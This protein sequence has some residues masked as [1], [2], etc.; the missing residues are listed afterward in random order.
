MLP[1]KISLNNYNVTPTLSQYEETFT[2]KFFHSSISDKLVFKT[3]AANMKFFLSS[4]CFLLLISNLHQVEP[5]CGCKKLTR[6]FGSKSIQGICFNVNFTTLIQQPRPTRNMILI[7]GGRYSIGTNE[8]V[9]KLDGESPQ[10]PVKLN[11]FYLDKYE[12]SIGEFAEFVSKTGYITDAE[13]F[14]D[15]FI[16]YS[17]IENYTEKRA[18]ASVEV[19]WW[20]LIKGVSWDHPEGSNT[21]IKDRLNHPVNH[22]SWFD[23]VTYCNW[24]G[25]RLPTE[26]EWEVACKGANDD[27][28]YPWGDEFIPNGKHMAN[29]WQGF[30]PYRNTGDD[31]Y[32]TLAP[33]DSFKQGSLGL[34]NII[35]NLWEWTNDF[36]TTKHSKKLQINPQGPK[37]STDKVKKGGSFMCHKDYC[38]RFR[39]AAR[40]QNT[41]DSS[42]VNIGFRCAKS[43]ST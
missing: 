42:S 27:S 30:F 25:K 41:P 7:P 5:S 19:P 37:N 11:D 12:V 23:A 13:R 20:L 26:A 31:G 16:L 18:P 22:I 35:G 39:C 24:L 29:T 43:I 14:G 40:S 21:T 33:V 1:K 9:I 4:V 8:P 10:R 3:T 28:I 2:R 17:M 15:S 34:H 6:V 36:W 32:T 38:F